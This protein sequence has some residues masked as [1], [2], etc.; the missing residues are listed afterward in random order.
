MNRLT[1]KQAQSGHWWLTQ[2]FPGTK[3]GWRGLCL[4]FRRDSES[5]WTASV[6]DR[7]SP[8]RII[9]VSC[10]SLQ[11]AARVAEK[12]AETH[13]FEVAERFPMEAKI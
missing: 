4:V 8:R 11:Q 13:G 6:P 7:D 1:W 9:D 5:P 12:W 10:A 2:S 3:V